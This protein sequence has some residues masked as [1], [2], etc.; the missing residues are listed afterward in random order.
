MFFTTAGY[1]GT[2]EYTRTQNMIKEMAKGEGKFVFGANWE[3]PVHFGLLTKKFVMDIKN[4]DTTSPISF[5]QNYESI[6]VGAGEGALINM[7]KVQA[8]RSEEITPVLK[9][10]GKSEFIISMDVARSQFQNNNQS[11]FVVGQIIRN[12]NNQIRCVDI[13]N[14]IIP[15][16][17]LTFQEQTI[18][19]K[20]LQKIYN[21]KAVVVDAN[22][23]GKGIMDECLRETED[24]RTGEFYDCWDCMNIDMKP[25]VQGSKKIVYGLN[26]SGINTDIIVNFWDYIES[27]K[28]RFLVS[29]RNAH[30]NPKINEEIKANMMVSHMN[31]DL[32]MDEL[33]N[34]KVEKPE[35]SNTFKI[36]QVT[37]KIDK[38]IYSALVYLLYYVQQCET[39]KPKVMNNYQDY[40]FYN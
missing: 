38:D 36:K 3:L 2:V 7:D 30:I 37:R 10:D 14:I 31:T 39:S 4:D 22:G 23:V 6:W 18:I 16:N 32:L 1:K 33:S 35:G 8:L 13:V 20:R 21:A 9:Y 11:A 40:I 29:E 34:L 12:K 27:A 24:K 25:D 15:E 17:G 19:L 26:A 5:L 28:V